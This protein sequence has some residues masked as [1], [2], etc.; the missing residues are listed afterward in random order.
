M[1]C[2]R[3]GKYPGD[4]NLVRASVLLWPY[5]QEPHQVLVWIQEVTPYEPANRRKVIIV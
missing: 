3:L 1:P 2:W 5:L 4:H